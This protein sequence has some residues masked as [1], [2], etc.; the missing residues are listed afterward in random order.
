MAPV[1]AVTTSALEYYVALPL[2]QPWLRMQTPYWIGLLV[3]LTSAAAYPLHFLLRSPAEA[4][5]R[6][7]AAGVRTAALLGAALGAM[8][9]PAALGARR[10]E[11]PWPVDD[12]SADREFLRR[13]TH[14]HEIGVMLADLVVARSDH[15][16]LRALARLMAAEQEAQI[17]A[18]AGWWASWFGGA[19]PAMAP[20]DARQMPGMPS[21]AELARLESATGP[22]F[23]RD[24][25]AVMGHHH[26]G[27]IEMAE[28]ALTAAADPR[29]RL[30]AA[31]IKHAQ[32]GQKALMEHIAGSGGTADGGQAAGP[33][34]ARLQE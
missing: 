23:E 4:S 11:L 21:P 28:H 34:P 5:E 27:A 1:W 12:R 3:H 2:V 31:Q 16:D 20:D 10:R 6:D 25:A 7:R 15:P 18:M 8:A 13:M 22:S 29:V 14:H 32:I 24:F 26:A 19:I 17:D 33:A 9:I 30:L